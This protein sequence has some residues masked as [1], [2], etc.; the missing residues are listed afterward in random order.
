MLGKT[1]ILSVPFTKGSKKEILEEVSHWI[2]EK[3]TGRYIV[4]PN[5]EMIVKAQDDQA[6]LKTL[7]SSDLSLTD[8]V[9]VT[10]S[11]SFLG[12]SGLTRLTGVDMVDSLCRLASD[13]SSKDEKKPVTVGFLG[14]RG[15]VAERTGKCLAKKYPGLVISF[16][17]EEWD[18]QG[19]ENAK[20]ILGYKDTKR[21]RQDAQQKIS[22]ITIS[23]FPQID[24][25]FVAFGFPKQEFWMY[26][27]RGTIPVKVMMGVGGAFDYLSGDVKRAPKFIRDLGLEWLFRLAVQPWRWRRQLALPRF[28]YLVLKQRF[29]SK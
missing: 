22:N 6:F 19:F 21:L 3:Q 10:L 9:G 15:G 4:T 12:K 1:E 2:G 5:P 24:I 7:T 29:T 28:L 18:K 11:A 16:V 8:G 20:K 27:H 23:S 26:E 14:G 13:M 17:G 25:L